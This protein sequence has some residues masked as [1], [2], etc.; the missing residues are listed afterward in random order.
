MKRF[1]IHVSVGDLARIAPDGEDTPLFDL[2]FLQPAIRHGQ[3]S[4][5]AAVAALLRQARLPTDDLSSAPGLRVWMLEIEG[6]L[7]GAV[8]LEGTEPSSRL[9]RSL[10]IVPAHQRRGLGRDLVAR[11][12]RDARAEG[13]EQLVLLTETARSLF[14]RLGYEVIGRAAAPESLRQSAQFRSLCPASA[15]CMAKRLSPSRV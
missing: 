15:V 6:E 3:S 11:V 14:E 9:L 1:H 8:A 4:D 13:I 10:V 12:E 2:G 5:L 7:A